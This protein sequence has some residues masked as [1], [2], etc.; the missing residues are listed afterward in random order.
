MLGLTPGSYEA[1]CF[2]QAVLYLGNTI[3]TELNKVGH[4]PAKGEKANERNRER[5]LVKFLGEKAMPKPKY[6]DPA[7]LF[8]AANLDG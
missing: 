4:K 3:T 7:A 5:V 6:A 1:Y 8:Q 2:D